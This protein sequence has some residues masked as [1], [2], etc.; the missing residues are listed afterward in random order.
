[1]EKKIFAAICLIVIAI[2]DLPAQA[3]VKPPGLT[4][5]PVVKS[6]ILPGMGEYSLQNSQRGRF[7][8]MTEIA[9]LTGAIGL[10]T[11]A[12]Y[13]KTTYRAFAAD[14]A[15]V[16][17]GDKSDAFWIDIGNYISREEHNTEHLRFREFDVLYPNDEYWNWEWDSVSQRASY[18]RQRVAHDRLRL[19]A[20]FAFG[21][22]ALNHLVSAVD[23]LYLSRIAGIE[24]I[25]YQPRIDGNGALIHSLVLYF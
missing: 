19:A 17:G 14:H 10:H 22:L 25:S 12:D 11:R 20:Q 15:G 16:S 13:T 8:M 18:S 7:F 24:E 9:L 5:S 2:A 23:A 4:L 6:L 21:G 1:M 3:A